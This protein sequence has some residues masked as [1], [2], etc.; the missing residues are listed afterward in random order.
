MLQ[1]CVTRPESVH[2]IDRT[3]PAVVAALEAANRAAGAFRDWSSISDKCRRMHLSRMSE[4]LYD[5]R[6]ELREVAVEEIGAS[7]GW[8]DFNIKIAR[9]ML[10]NAAELLTL[11]RDA[12]LDDSERGTRSLLRRKPVGVVLG[13]APWNA[14]ITLAV[15]ALAAPLACGNSAVFKASELCPETH[16][17]LVDIL[18]GT[19]LPEG[20]IGAV[21]NPPDRSEVVVEALIA[22]PAIRRVNFTGSSRVGREIARM[23]AR[24]LKRCLLELSSKA[25]MIVLED[26]DLDSAAS[27]AAFGAFFNQG[28]VC[29]STERI[30]V[31]DSAADAFLE[32]LLSRVQRLR[33]A[34][35]REVEEPLGALINP[36]SA[37]RVRRL[38]DDAISKG[39]RLLAG[40]EV[41]GPVMQPAVVDGVAAHMA[42]YHEESFGP[43]ASVL[44]VMDEEEAVSIANDSEFG[45]AAAVYSADEAR[46]MRIA[47]RLET[48]IAHVNGPTLYDDP[49]MPFG[50][51]K[52]SGYGRFG[53][54]AS[55]D[56]FTEL[57]WIA[58]HDRACVPPPFSSANLQREDMPCTAESR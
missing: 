18:N 15:R 22:H 10:E 41:E 23:A 52:A 49:A 32:K 24:Y 46:A 29:I 43:V 40:G 53:G 1:T 7:P 35:P 39:A 12:T 45:L 31:I 19:G 54:H 47:D 4:A 9:E 30:I 13:I 14:P 51:M 17:L 25:S 2:R 8:V 33:A 5:R 21:A 42:L 58:R 48:G 16:L 36:E 3:E 55:L 27:A 56:E 44:R 50:G 34:D 37:A 28:Q 57:R 6:A 11:M 38:I 26:A 20:V